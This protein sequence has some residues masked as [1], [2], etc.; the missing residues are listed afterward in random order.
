MN[1]IMQWMGTLPSLTQCMVMITAILL[2]D[3]SWVWYTRR[4][5]SG[6]PLQS[7]YAATAI[8]LTGAIAAIGYITNHWLV[9]IGA[10]ASF[11][12]TTVA[13]WFDHSRK[14]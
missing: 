9:L 13:V 12:G 11:F 8:Y 2:N 6:N 14:K 4:V 7:G 10:M 3:F 1:E 5:T